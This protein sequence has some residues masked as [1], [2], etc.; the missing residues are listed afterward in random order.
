MWEKRQSSQS[1]EEL[2]CCF[3]Y[4]YPEPRRLTSKPCWIGSSWILMVGIQWR[5]LG[6]LDKELSGWVEHSNTVSGPIAY[7]SCSKQ[8]SLLCMHMYIFVCISVDAHVI[9]CVWRS[10]NELSHWCLLSTWRQSAVICH[11]SYQA[12][13]P[14]NFQGFFWL[15]LLSHLGP[16]G[17]LM[18]AVMPSITQVLGTQSQIL[19]WVLD[20]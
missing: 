7:T 19:I 15:H 6:M 2:L 16:Q 17:L 3:F 1:L 13:Q 14:V 5:C 9:A 20:H 11:S 12:S 18:L 10:E 8:R 4:W